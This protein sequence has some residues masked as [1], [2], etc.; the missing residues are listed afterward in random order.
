KFPPG[1]PHGTLEERPFAYPRGGNHSG[2]NQEVAMGTAQMQGSLWG[3]GARDYADLGEAAFRPLYEAVLD[4]AG[5]RAGTRLLAGGCGPGLAALLAARR[6]AEVAGLDAAETSVAIARERTPAGDF[7]V[8][9]ME[10]LP[11]PDGTFDVVT[12]FNAF[13]YAADPINA[14]REAR[15]VART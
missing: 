11:W 9:E 14:L 12:G 7:R 8:G 5:G 3:V 6:G 15:R 1:T 10:E 2:R 13:Q 4:V